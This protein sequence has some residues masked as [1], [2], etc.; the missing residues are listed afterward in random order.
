MTEKLFYQDA[1]LTA[2]DATIKQV[3]NQEGKI[4]LAFDRTAFYPEGG[5]QG[6]D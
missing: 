3:R 6:P 1:Y 4:L 2:F 5:G